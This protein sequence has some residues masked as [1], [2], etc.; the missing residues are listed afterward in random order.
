M[1]SPISREGYLGSEERDPE[2]WRCARPAQLRVLCVAGI[3]T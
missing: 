1:M 3:S 2:V